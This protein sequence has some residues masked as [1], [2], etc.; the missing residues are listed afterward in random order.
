MCNPSGGK[1]LL[2]ASASY[3]KLLGRVASRILP[4]THDGA[5]PRKA[6]KGLKTSTVSQKKSDSDWK[7]TAVS[8]TVK[9]L[10]LDRTI[11]DLNCGDLEIPHVGI[12]LGVMGP[13]K[14]VFVCLLDL[15]RGNGEQGWCDLV[16][17]EYP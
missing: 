5:L 7:G 1:I 10:R 8:Y 6:T 3:D 9:W 15:L 17:V 4:N 16:Y 14:T 2:R 13:K 11:T 12:R